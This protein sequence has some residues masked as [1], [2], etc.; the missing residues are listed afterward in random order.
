VTDLIKG[1]AGKLRD[2]WQ[3]KG[4]GR[5]LLELAVMG[6]VAGLA[7]AACQ[8]FEFDDATTESVVEVVSM[9]AAAYVAKLLLPT[10]PASEK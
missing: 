1:R 2:R 7:R 8:W 10:L 3:R 5:R 9:I 6:A 4:S